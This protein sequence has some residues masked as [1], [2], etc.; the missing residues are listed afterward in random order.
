[1]NVLGRVSKEKAISVTGKQKKFL[2]GQKN[3]DIGWRMIEKSVMDRLLF[4][5]LWLYRIKIV[6]CRTNENEKRL[7]LSVKHGGGNMM[8]W[9]CVGADK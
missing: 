2:N 7:M 8:V 1:M 6:R 4:E 5:V 3:T 9:G